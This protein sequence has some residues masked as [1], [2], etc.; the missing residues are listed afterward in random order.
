VIDD[1]EEDHVQWFRSWADTSRWLEEYEKKHAEFT[2]CINYFGKMRIVWSD[3]A[4]KYR[5][6]PGYLA[7]ALR[8]SAMFRTL[9]DDARVH[10]Q[11]VG[12]PVIVNLGNTTLAE[13]VLDFHKRE[14]TWL[15]AS[16][17]LEEVNN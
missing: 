16:I 8:Q 2:R 4:A 15:A 1:R 5:H 10:Y 9:A 3:I 14:T 7:F 11:S 12:D 6:E 13:A 17:G